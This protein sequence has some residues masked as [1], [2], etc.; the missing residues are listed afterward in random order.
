MSIFKNGCHR[1]KQQYRCGKCGY[2]YVKTRIKKFSIEE[3]YTQY[4]LGKQTLSEL[5]QQTGKCTRTLQRQFDALVIERVNKAVPDEPLNL[6]IDATFFSRSD[7]VF[8][9]RARKENLY[10]RF[11][12]S[13]TLAELSAGLDVLDQRGYRW[14]SITVDGRRGTI[15]LCEA[16]Y[17]GIPIQLCQFHQKQIIRRYTTNRPKTACGRDLKKLMAQLTEIDSKLFSEKLKALEE[18]YSNFLKERNTQG[19]FKHR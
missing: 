8:V 6:V 17:P 1:G 19:D 13:E 14:K 15:K 9:F 5:S 4:C 10:W 12:S 2:Q 16:R 11:I 18:S 3:L 7:G